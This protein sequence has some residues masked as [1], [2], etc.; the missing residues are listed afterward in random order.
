[1]QKAILLVLAAALTAAPLAQELQ[2]E[3]VAVNVEVPVRVFKG[4]TFIDNLTL[5]DFEIYEDGKPQKIEAMYLIK[6]TGIKREEADMDEEEARKKFLPQVS[7]NFVLLFE[8]HEYFPN[9]GKAVE[10]FFTDVL[11]PEDTLMIITP[12]KTYKFN[13]I[14][15]DMFTRKEI[16]EDF[17]EKLRKDIKI[18]SAVYRSL[19]KDLEN[20]MMFYQTSKEQLAHG[21]DT[22]NMVRM[23][24]S[25]IL[26]KLRNLR[27]IDEKKLLDFA[28]LLKEMEGQKYVFFFHQKLIVPLLKFS[29]DYQIEDL[30]DFEAFLSFDVEKAKMAFSD[31]SISPHFI[32]FTKTS[33][34]DVDNR[35]EIFVT[36]T[37]LLDT[38]A[39]DT[40]THIEMQD[41]SGSFYDSFKE[42]VQ[43][44]GGTVDSS[45]NAASSLKK[46]VYASENYYLLYYAPED[47]K[48]DGKF[49][50]IKVK[51]KNRNYRI[52]HR[53]GYIAD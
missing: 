26:T 36:S 32:F 2:H 27:H 52:S 47:Y 48:A 18:S 16:A 15:W 29:Q 17:K 38:R 24:Y 43:A 33:R 35:D 39:I 9:V 3:A 46:A 10:Y 28:N 44:A 20:I 6:K 45:A 42:I 1:M 37:N 50:E 22:V 13:N 25:N 5:E 14:A 34:L 51:V 40:G 23:M 49:R 8:L 53:A 7:R 31:S 4:D 21:D 41:L 11:Q 30:E 19:V 12:S